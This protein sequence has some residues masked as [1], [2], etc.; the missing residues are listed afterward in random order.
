MSAIKLCGDQGAR[1]VPWKIDGAVR[2]YRRN[3]GRKQ[4]SEVA[5]INHLMP[6]RFHCVV[7]QVLVVGA[8]HLVEQDAPDVMKHVVQTFI[9]ESELNITTA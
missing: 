2:A 9:Q 7:P 8:G 3:D 4:L 5:Y 1:Q 6:T